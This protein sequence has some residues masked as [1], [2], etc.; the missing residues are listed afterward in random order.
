MS[1]FFDTN[2]IF[3][4]LDRDASEKQSHAMQLLVA[5]LSEGKSMFISTQ[6]MIETI[7]V[8]RRRGFSGTQIAKVLE[9]LGEF[10]CETTTRETVEN[11]WAL[12]VANKL[13]WF[14]ALIVQAALQAG[15]KTLYSED[16][17][18]GQKFGALR[19]VNPFLN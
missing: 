6:V 19:V 9:T 15:C 4:S 7:S 8:C 1:V 12:Q 5:C 14:D 2:V 11:A 18:H 16:M 17:Q 3:Y 13:S 10:Q